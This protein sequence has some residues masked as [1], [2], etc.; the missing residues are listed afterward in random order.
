MKNIKK[1]YLYRA[2]HIFDFR[3]VINYKINTGD[4]YKRKVKSVGRE[5]RCLINHVN[6]LHKQ[7]AA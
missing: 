4:Q 1:K 2:V 3:L 7:E 5:A 6:H